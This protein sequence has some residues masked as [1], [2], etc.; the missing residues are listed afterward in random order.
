MPLA[1]AYV[2]AADGNPHTLLAGIPDLTDRH[3]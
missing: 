2:V 1:H 3:G